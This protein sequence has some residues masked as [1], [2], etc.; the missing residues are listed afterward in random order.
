M[1]YWLRLKSLRRLKEEDFLYEQ[2]ASSSLHDTVT[3]TTFH[4]SKDAMEGGLTKSQIT[5][6]ILS[7]FGILGNTLT[8]Q[9]FVR[10]KNLLKKV[11]QRFHSLPCRI[12]CADSQAQNLGLVTLFVVQVMKF[13]V[14]SSVLYSGVEFFSFNSYF[15][16]FTSHSCWQ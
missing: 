7:I 15:S 4:W 2:F 6:C 10:D 8:I 1:A 9:M 13:Q 16:P 14:R 11:L 12:W 3:S 5:N